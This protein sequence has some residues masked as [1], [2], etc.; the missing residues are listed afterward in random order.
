MPRNL[1]AETHLAHVLYGK[2]IMGEHDLQTVAR[3]SGLSAELLYKLCR[4]QRSLLAWHI[5]AIYRGTQDLELYAELVGAADCRLRVSEQGPKESPSSDDTREA[6]LMVGASAGDI[7]H[8][9]VEAEADNEITESECTRI[10]KQIDHHERELERLRGLLRR[11]V[12]LV[13]G[14][15]R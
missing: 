1:D 4:G 10:E 5:P 15:E 6:A 11:R 3:R 9:I 8:S 12:R 2:L 7:Q 13:G 14:S